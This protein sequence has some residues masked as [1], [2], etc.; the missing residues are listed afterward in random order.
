[1]RKLDQ[2]G[3]H[4][5]NLTIHDIA[6]LAEVSPMTVSRVMNGKGGVRADKRERVSR[7]IS[8][9][10]FQPHMGAQS[11][12]RTCG[13]AVGLVFPSSIEQSPFLNES[14][15]S[16]FIEMIYGVFG[17][18]GKYICLDFNPSAKGRG[19]NYARGLWQQRYGACIVSGPL[20]IADRTIHRIHASGRPYVALGRL[21]TLPEISCATVDC[22]LGAY[23]CAK[24]LIARGHTRIAMLS[25]FEGSHSG[26]ER[27]RGYVCALREAGIEVDERLMR[28]VTYGSQ[29]V[30]NAVYRLLLNRGV[31][32]FIDCSSMEDAAG[33]R[34]GARLA[35]R[36][37]GKDVECV[38]WTYSD[39]TTVMREAVAHLWVPAREAA[40]EGIELLAKWIRGDRS[41]PIHVVYPPTLYR[42]S[43]LTAP[44]FE[45]LR[46]CAAISPA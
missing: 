2:V 9:M 20:A 21:D 43:G 44:E 42:T 1:M 11:L 35:A 29:E 17:R 36:T 5:G 7:I 32:A 18:E 27:R 31:T 8:E 38:V 13:D 45:G 34:E 24:L 12:R 22:E 41:V 37:L 30:A 33:L 4:T 15:V 39:S 26:E 14:F 25:S 6:K 40:A 19:E 28:S 23:T 46:E 3:P 10:G 16:W